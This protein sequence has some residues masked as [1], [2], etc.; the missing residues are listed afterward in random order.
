[1]L[2]GLQGIVV[3]VCAQADFVFIRCNPVHHHRD[4]RNRFINRGAYGI[5]QAK[6]AVIQ[7]NRRI[8]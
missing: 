3:F 1:M 2:Y 7:T 5:D 6:R 8:R 4:N